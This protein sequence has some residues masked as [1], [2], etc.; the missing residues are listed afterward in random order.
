[1]EKFPSAGSGGQEIKRPGGT[2][3]VFILISNLGFRL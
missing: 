1:M 3:V 2:D